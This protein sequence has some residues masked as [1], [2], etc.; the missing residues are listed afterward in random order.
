M[1]TFVQL[2]FDQGRSARHENASI[3]SDNAV[4]SN[5]TFGAQRRQG[6]PQL[7]SKPYEEMWS[8]YNKM[9]AQKA[10]YM[11]T[12]PIQNV[13]VDD[14][15]NYEEWKPPVFDGFTPEN[16]TENIRKLE[17]LLDHERRKYMYRVRNDNQFY[18]QKLQRSNYTFSSYY[19]N[20]T[21]D[22]IDKLI[23]F[24]FDIM[25]QEWKINNTER[26]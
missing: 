18:I 19:N 10:S 8:I 22:Q 24:T 21:F 17:E 20:F 5:G 25:K 16:I 6:A 2:Q 15:F 14:N 4:I 23:Y 3:V 26:H 7:S 12:T 11:I 13:H 9:A 1:I